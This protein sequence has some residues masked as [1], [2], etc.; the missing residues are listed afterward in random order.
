MC[1]PD[2]LHKQINVKIYNF[3]LKN[4]RS[5]STLYVGFREWHVLTKVLGRR[6]FIKTRR[7]PDGRMGISFAGVPVY[8]VV[9]ENHMDVC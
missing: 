1:N 8:R 7:Q 3:K 4:H 2:N 5:P 6:P 9:A